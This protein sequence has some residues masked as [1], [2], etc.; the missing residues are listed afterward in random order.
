MIYFVRHGE[1]ESNLK[2][3]FAGQREDSPLTQ[4]GR[5]QAL[6]TAKNIKQENIHFE[7]I[8]SGPLKRV[9]ET[10]H[11]IAHEIGFDISKIE[12][13]SRIT[14]Y[15]MGSLTG[16]PIHKI[17]SLSLT[18]AKNAEDVDTFKKRILECITELTQQNNNILVVSHAGVGR[19]LE[20][21]KEN[22]DPHLFYDLPAYPNASII[23][24]NWI[25]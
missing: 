6:N 13:D 17:S 10:A 14:E 11:I 9:S 3:I 1:S 4:K 15:D 12:V 20:T 7:R 21:V 19:L 24:I 23:I 2:D 18:S 5:E 22:M 16:T 25:K 8:V